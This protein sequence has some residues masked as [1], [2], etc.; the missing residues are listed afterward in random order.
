MESETQTNINSLRRKLSSLSAWFKLEETSL[1]V[2]G[3]RESVALVTTEVINMEVQSLPDILK[4]LQLRGKV[5]GLAQMEHSFHNLL[6]G[7]E[8]ELKELES[9]NNK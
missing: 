4:L 2:E 6:A 1:V 8:D 5:Q 7:L 9:D 3:L